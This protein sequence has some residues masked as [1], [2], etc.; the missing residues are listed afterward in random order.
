[1]KC[2]SFSSKSLYLR[3]HLDFFDIC[4]CSLYYGIIFFQYF[5]ASSI[6]VWSYMGT[7]MKVLNSLLLYFSY[8]FI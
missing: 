2:P 6:E 5:L 4:E 3:N 7:D 1:M 8:H